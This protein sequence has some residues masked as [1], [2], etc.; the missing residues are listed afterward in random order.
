MNSMNFSTVNTKI[1]AMNAK[2]L[3]DNDFT[4]I[5]NLQSVQEIFDYL[6]EDTALA[7]VLWDLKGVQ[8]HI[9]NFEQRLFQNKIFLVEKLMT[10]FNQEYKKLIKSYMLRYEIENLKL[11]FE[12]L[13]G[14]KKVENLMDH[15]FVFNNFS[16]I[17][18]QSLLK[19][20]S[21]LE[22]VEEIK[23]T[24][25]YRLILPYA[26]NEDEKFNF[27]VGMILN[28]YYYYQLIRNTQEIL[29][30]M[31]KKSIELLRRKIDLFNLEW[32]YRGMKYYDISKEEILNLVLDYGYLY[33]YNKLKDIIYKFD[34]NNIQEQ[35]IH[36]PYEFLFDDKDNLDLFMDIRI[37][38][39]LYYKSLNLYNSSVLS[40]G[41]IAAFFELI[42]FQIKD[43]ISIIESK[44]YQMPAEEITKYL[45]RKIKVV[46]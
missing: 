22:V 21:V 40:F 26:Q 41:K 42:D 44:R 15:F 23:D 16:N 30:D 33:N 37:D 25:Y 7:D 1:S 38:R 43:I 29:G 5:M 12:V 46:V 11:V 35:F 34:L 28:K 32:I 10:Y 27:Y 6:N 36:T 24:K 17:D 45:I 9:N 2:L 19:K 39:Y 13:Q 20:K 4:Y 18:Y 31:D 14:R 3:T 8:V